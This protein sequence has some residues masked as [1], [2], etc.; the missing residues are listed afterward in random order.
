MSAVMLLII[1]VKLGLLSFF[2]FGISLLVFQFIKKIL[3]MANMNST[4]AGI[5]FNSI[6][7]DILA[8]QSLII[9]SNNE[10]HENNFFVNE[11]RQL[12]KKRFYFEQIQN[13]LNPL[14]IVFQMFAVI[15]MAILL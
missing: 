10:E 11:Y 5:N 2:F 4:V 1:N 15:I 8:R 6:L 14:F 9:A 13:L 3:Y 12:M 7:Q